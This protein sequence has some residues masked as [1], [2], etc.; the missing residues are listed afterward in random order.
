[1]SI[2]PFKAT[3]LKEARVRDCFLPTLELLGNERDN[4]DAGAYEAFPLGDVL[5]ATGHPL[6]STIPMEVF[7]SSF[8]AINEFF[9]RPGTFEFYIE[10]FKKVWG[11]D[12]EIEFTVPAPGKLLISIEALSI[13][14]NLAIARRIVSNAYV[15][16]E[17]I[18][19]DGDNLIFQG[20]QGLQTQREAE[21]LVLEL[22]PNGIWVEIDLTIS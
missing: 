12:A 5:F 3:D 1:M 9:Q 10:V 21:A 19:E 11:E 18:D 14:F 6:A 4:F 2:Q 20:T 8:P 15:Y 7:R 13:Q 17:L 16:D 22:H